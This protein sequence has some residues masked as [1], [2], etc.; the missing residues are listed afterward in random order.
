MS[1]KATSSGGRREGKRKGERKKGRKEGGKKERK[2][3]RNYRQIFLMNI[4]VQFF[5][6]I[7]VY[8][9]HQ[10]I[11]RILTTIKFDLFQG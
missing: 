1:I 7:L 9:I 10:Y 5:G 11:K 3:G 2:K 4:D 8:Q 6:K